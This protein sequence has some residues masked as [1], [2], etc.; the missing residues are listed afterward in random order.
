MVDALTALACSRVADAASGL[1]MHSAEAE[2]FLLGGR[3]KSAL[4]LSLGAKGND[5]GL[6]LVESQT[7]ETMILR[8]FYGRD[9][10]C[11]CHLLPPLA[12]QEA[13]VH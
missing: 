5:S 8:V 6:Y 3:L 13:T 9:A 12:R 11:I 7:G 10:L 1:V 2:A 4:P